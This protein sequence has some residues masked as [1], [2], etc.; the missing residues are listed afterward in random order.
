MKTDVSVSI[1]TLGCPKNQVDSEFIASALSS[2]TLNVIHSEDYADIVLINTCGF[3]LDAREQSVDTI[4][5]YAI[6]RKE[7]KIKKLIVFGCLIEKF[8]AQLKD[9]IPEVDAWFGVN[10]AQ[11]ISNSILSDAKIP[12]ARSN[13]ML[14][15]PKHYA[16][17]KISEGCDRQCAFCAIPSIRGNHISRPME[18]IVSEAVSL[19]NNG[20]K[21]LIVIAQ[22]TTYYG[23]DLYGKRKLP[24]LMEQLST[25]SGATWIRLHYTYPAGF[26]I[27]L[28]DVMVRCPNICRYIDIPF[29]HV[30]HTLLA[31][32]MRYHTAKDI[33]QLIAEFRKKIPEIH[34]RT[35][36]ITGFPGEGKDE[37]NE[38]VQFLKKYKIERAGFFAYSPEEN[39]PAESFG[40]PVSQKLKLQ[41]LRKLFDI[42]E[43]ISF[44]LNL[45]KVGSM[46]SVMIDEVF[47][48][49]LLGRTEFDSPDID[50][51]VTVHV[52]NSLHFKQGDIIRVKITG[53]DAWDLIAEPVVG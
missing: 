53:A 17:L 8:G 12:T 33:E 38:M 28:I 13:S 50:N 1:I 40:D 20:V 47:D 4:L 6:A 9:E 43:K 35:T 41:R 26:P 27:E 31:R 44:E 49:Y 48:T 24:E 21:E 36:M 46:M 3:I 39:T 5:K 52:K 30:N 7:G 11:E 23:L 15:T 34:I 16:F 51:M 14:S 22:D 32:M 42:Q 25:Q 10:D 19:V 18:E 2:D 29:Q 37:F 45:K